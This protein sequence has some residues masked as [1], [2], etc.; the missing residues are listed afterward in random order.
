MIGIPPWGCH[1]EMPGEWGARRERVCEELVVLSSIVWRTET[2][3]GRATTVVSPLE[4]AS[5]RYWAVCS[6][7]RDVKQRIVKIDI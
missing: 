4:E 5:P 3:Q 2:T 6:Y 1:V 7:F